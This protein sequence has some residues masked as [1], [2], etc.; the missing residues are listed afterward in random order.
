MQQ[1]KGSNK[2]FKKWLQSFN[3]NNLIPATTLLH[4]DSFLKTCDI[5]KNKPGDVT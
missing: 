4:R 2:P 3:G 5:W 1:Q